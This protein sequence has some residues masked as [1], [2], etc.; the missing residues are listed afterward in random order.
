LFV[1]DEI[2]SMDGRT[3]HKKV[4]DFG[5]AMTTHKS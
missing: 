5:Y 2:K 4:V 1:N 3:L